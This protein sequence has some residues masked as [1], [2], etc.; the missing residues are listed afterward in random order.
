MILHIRHV[1]SGQKIELLGITDWQM[2]ATTSPT[3]T[4]ITVFIPSQTDHIPSELPLENWRPTSGCDSES[5]TNTANEV[6]QYLSETVEYHT[7]Q[8]DTTVWVIPSSKYPVFKNED[9]FGE[10]YPSEDQVEQL[11]E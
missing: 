7:H 6:S 1:H 2:N 5:Y 4:G 8:P 10:Y 11:L 9:A 3:R